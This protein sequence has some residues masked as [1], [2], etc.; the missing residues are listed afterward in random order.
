MVLIICPS[1]HRR[2]SKRA[3]PPDNTVLSSWAVQV[4]SRKLL[5]GFDPSEPELHKTVYLLAR[6]LREKKPPWKNSLCVS[7]FF[8]VIYCP[9]PQLLC[10]NQIPIHTLWHS[11]QLLSSRLL[12]NWLQYREP[13]LGVFNL[14]CFSSAI[15]VQ[16]SWGYSSALPWNLWKV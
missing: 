8:P 16:D 10:G 6:W 15:R 7:S 2:F 12:N 14:T 11:L 3:R 1:P 9:P 13:Y 4:L 5:I